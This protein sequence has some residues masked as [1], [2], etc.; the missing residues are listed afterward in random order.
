MITIEQ[1]DTW[2][3][4][5]EIDR[6]TILRE[7]LQVLFLAYLYRLRGSQALYFKGGTA[8]R[9]LQGSFRFSEDLDFSS[10]LSATS[11]I[12]LLR[13]AVTGAR[14]EAP[15]ISLDSW[16]AKAQSVRGRLVYRSAWTAYPLTISLEVSRRERPIAPRTSLLETV[17]PVGAFPWVRHLDW[18]E[19]LA[20]KVRA[21]ASRA[22]GRD[23][24]D[25]WYLL[26]K[27]IPLLWK[28]VERKMRFYKKS[29]KPEELLENIRSLREDVLKRD[30][31]AFLPR[32]QRPL[33]SQL[34]ATTL[35]RLE[36]IANSH[37]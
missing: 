24:F 6:F 27:E 34:K 25:L 18:P 17:Y 35:R 2:A 26:S 1:A 33:I 9:L 20:E 31:G 8:I 28:M 37:R 29:L 11:L 19:I 7:Y 10:Q 16:E 12:E 13:S 15:G 30:L 3:K 21:L 32:S 14:R 22:K 36:S 23:L 4:R 5:F